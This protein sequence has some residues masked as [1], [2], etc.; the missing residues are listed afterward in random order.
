MLQIWARN[1]SSHLLVSLSFLWYVQT[2][3]TCYFMVE[4]QCEIAF[5]TCCISP[6]IP[7]LSGTPV[8]LLLFYFLIFCLSPLHTFILTQLTRG[9]SSLSFPRTLTSWVPAMARSAPGAGRSLSSGYGH[10]KIKQAYQNEWLFSVNS[11]S[12]QSMTVCDIDHVSVSLSQNTKAAW[13][14]RPNYK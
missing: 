8:S 4:H 10:Y 11:I 3:S 5:K 12:I 7:R 14:K 9:P 1:P 6:F 13:T 2:V